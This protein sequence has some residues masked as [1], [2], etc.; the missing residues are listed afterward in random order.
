MECDGFTFG[1]LAMSDFL[2]PHDFLLDT[3]ATATG[4]VRISMP[5]AP[6]VRLEDVLYAH[7]KEHPVTLDLPPEYF[8]WISKII[9]FWSLGEW[10]LLG[11]LGEL[12]GLDRKAG[13]VVFGTRLGDT[14]SKIKQMMDLKQIE[15]PA[16][17]N[18]FSEEVKE[19]EQARNL[20]AHGVW[21]K[22]KDT[23]ELCIQNPSGEWVAKNADNRT[24]KASKRNFPEAVYIDAQWF[25][26]TFDK[27]VDTLGHIQF[28][29]QVIA[30]AKKP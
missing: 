13:R 27:V 8:G 20:I 15:I 1:D 18:M 17:W 16:G 11:T 28:L 29:D 9:T 10:M 7:I 12:T 26:D 22:D 24:V 6:R 4:S 14:I 23:G 3:S 21:M 5:L 19:C 2:K 25:K 30:A